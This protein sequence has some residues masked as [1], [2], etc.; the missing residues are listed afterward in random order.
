MPT[1]PESSRYRR[2]R[3]AKLRRNALLKNNAIVDPGPADAPSSYERLM[4]KLNSLAADAASR[5]HGAGSPSPLRLSSMNAIEPMSPSQPMSSSQP[6]ATGGASVPS[7]S[8]VVASS[9]KPEAAEA[10]I[11]SQESPSQAAQ[12]GQGPLDGNSPPD[13]AAANEAADSIPTMKK[14]RGAPQ[15]FDANARIIYCKLL[16]RGLAK[17]DAAR[18]IGVSRETVS[19]A[20]RDPQ[21]DLRVRQAVLDCRSRAAAQIARAGN[22]HWRAAAWVLGERRKRSAA[23]P[24]DLRP[25]L[26]DKRF[27]DTLKNAILEVLGQLLPDHPIGKASQTSAVNSSPL[28]TPVITRRDFLTPRERIS[29]NLTA[30]IMAQSE[31]SQSNPQTHVAHS[32]AQN[33]KQFPSA[34][35]GMTAEVLLSPDDASAIS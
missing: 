19:K 16:R 32:G 26:S 8:Q 22:T 25:L 15:V 29:A 28:D 21:F 3:L 30:E 35:F 4:H 17:T 34:P 2:A 18:L 10:V 27:R 9:S 13:Q 20:R 24:R 33:V 6:I 7:Q 5:S 14:R 31:K 23:R 1:N 12:N 11:T